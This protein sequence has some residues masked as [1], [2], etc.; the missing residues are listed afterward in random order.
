MVFFVLAIQTLRVHLNPDPRIISQSQ[1]QYWAEV[2]V[3]TSRG[4]I[5]DRNGVPLAISVPVS[6]IF[7]DPKLWPTESADTLEPLFGKRASEKF[8]KT[9][10][11]RFHWVERKLSN[12]KAFTLLDKKIPGL[13]SIRENQRQYPHGQL[14]A[15][16]LGYSDVDDMGLAGVELAW[17]NVLYSPAQTRLLVRDAQGKLLDLVG[18]NAGILEHGYGDIRLTLDSRFQQI[19]EWKLKEGIDET[20][21][22][23][24]AVVCVDPSNGEVLAMA[25]YPTINPNDRS[26]FKNAEATRNN[27]IG[28]VYEPGSTLKPIIMGMAMDMG[29]TS[30]GHQFYCGGRVSVADGVIRNVNSVAHGMET[31]QTT[32]V[33]SCNV[34]MALLGMRL[35][36]YKAYNMLKQFGFGEKTGIEIAGEEEGLLRTPEQWLGIVPANIAIG[37]GLA[38]TPIQLAMA[39]SAIANGGSLLKPYLVA[40]VKNSKGEKI[41]QGKKRARAIVL[42]KKVSSW[43]RD[44]LRLTVVQGTAKGAK[45]DLAEIAGKTG[46]AQV[47]TRGNYIK[48][49]YVSS[50]VGFWPYKSPKYVLLVVLGEPKG[51]YYGG[52][53]AAPV[54]KSIVEDLVNIDPNSSQ[55]KE[56]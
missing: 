54:F 30:R 46:T 16:V 53:I 18:S 1:N 26:T 3:S 13:G 51:R 56:G 27:A 47:A 33:K 29:V 45:T 38:V 55:Q 21:A 41:Y 19:V 14:G 28:R 43:L 52:E 17:N 42:T 48:G 39:I 37:Q 36:K 22:E 50:F 49:Q 20:K 9:L 6:S 24:G 25:S 34:G 2:K 5:F 8:S 32:L 12:E 7:I 44:T 23:W 11:G 15:H 40:E 4:D 35:E 10:P 31:P